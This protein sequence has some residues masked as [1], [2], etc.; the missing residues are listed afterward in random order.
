MTIDLAI[1]ILFLVAN[2]LIG[3]YSSKAVTNFSIFS[4]GH[5]SFSSFLIF[6]TLSA[7]F[8]GGGYTFGNAA[9]VFNHG[10]VFAFALL[11]FSVKEL[12]VATLIAP[13]MGRYNDCHSVG[14]MIAKTY[15]TKAKMATG[16]FALLICGGILG[17]Q[18]GALTAI[19][20][21]TL[22]INVTLGVMIS[23]AVLLIYASLGGMRAVVFTDVMQATIL[24]VGIPL[25]F[26][27]GL[28]HV[29]GW[30]KVVATVPHHYL[31]FL[32]TGKDW[33]LFALLFVTF[34]FGETLV[35]PYVQRLFM[36]VSTK[37]T[38]RGVLVSGLVSI[39]I[40]LIAGAV[41]LVAYTANQHIDA[42]IA[43]PYVVSH[44]LPI[45]LRGFVIAALLAIILSSAAGFL[46]AASISFVNDLVKPLRKHPEK[47]DFLKMARISTLLV[48]VIAIFFALMIKN[49]L[50]LLLAAYNFWSP[51]ILVPLVAAIFNVKA[52][53]RDFFVGAICG[54][55]GSLTWQFILHHPFQVSP[56]LLGIV[57]NLIGFTVSLKTKS[58]KRLV[59]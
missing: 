48:G 37:Q 4:V 59:S 38:A 49:V 40:F 26:F 34:M 20:H 47:T 11:G 52:K 8:I 46:N 58:G 31:H 24:L 53:E 33:V 23:F 39:P 2:I 14:D 57:C 17:A 18:V 19:I 55:V 32:S 5:R 21:T 6:C 9:S 44:M 45:G 12:L 36:A 41:G 28:H 10:M 51:I 56:I 27:I 50:T 3:Y 13:R 22:D 43:F 30:H 7:T 16:V 29:G 54:I 35:P 1:V 15:G 25:T 42:N